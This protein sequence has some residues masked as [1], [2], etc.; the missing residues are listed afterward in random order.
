MKTRFVAVAAALLIVTGCATDGIND[1]IGAY[2]SQWVVAAYGGDA[3]AQYRLGVSYCCGLTPLYH[4]EIAAAWLCRP[5]THGPSEA[6]YQL[7]NIYTGRVVEHGTTNT[8]DRDDNIIDAF[9]LYTLAAS[10]RH[11]E[12]GRLR[13]RF[14]SSMHFDEI[15]LGRQRAEHWS[16]Q[17]CGSLPDRDTVA[18]SYG[19]YNNQYQPNFSHW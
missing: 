6:Q 16:E 18:P 9:A 15:V 3:E 14:E 8:G 17:D 11:A 19:R 12:A 2:R 10:N 4:T 7:A 5:S 13:D 1:D